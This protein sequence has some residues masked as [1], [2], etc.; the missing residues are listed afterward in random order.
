MTSTEHAHAQREWIVPGVAR[1]PTCRGAVGVRDDEHLF[2]HHR[3]A[4][5]AGSGPN[6]SH[7]MIRCE[8]E[9]TT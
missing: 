8:G 9:R 5:G 7:D 6:Q 4:D 1:C 2:E 3:Y